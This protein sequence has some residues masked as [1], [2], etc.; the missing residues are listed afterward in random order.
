MDRNLAQRIGFAAAA[1]PVALVLAWYGDWPLAGFL[2]LVAALGT[3]ELYALARR[4]GA[5]PL[6]LPGLV[7]AALTPPAVYLLLREPAGPL[8][9]AWPYLAALW[10]LAVLTAALRYRAPDRRPLE[11][12]ATTTFGVCYAAA[13]PAFMLGLRHQS[14]GP[15]SWAGAWL[16]FFPLVVTWICDTAAM[17]AGR[18]IGGRKL[19]PV[20]SPGKTRAGSVAGVLGGLVVVPPF[21]WWIFPAVGV[22]A[23][24]GALV[25]IA[26]VVSVVGQAGDLVESLFKRQAGVKDSSRLIPG[27][28]GVLDRLDSLYFVVPVSAGLYRAL[29]VG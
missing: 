15:R 11:A 1:T 4:S 8:H 27:H 7:G 5:D 26:L 21:H 20:V 13:L 17:F 28:G 2:A 19:A 3:R 24:L 10:L 14:H 6:E 25:A 16:L 22:R 12:V 29:G 23:S 18:A 9:G